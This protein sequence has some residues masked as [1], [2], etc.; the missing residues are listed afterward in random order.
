V[1]A[2]GDVITYTFDVTNTGN[3]TIN[4]ITIHDTQ[5]PPATQANLTGLSCPQSTLAPGATENCTATYTVTK[6][7]LLN[8]SITDTATATGTTDTGTPVTSNPSQATVLATEIVMSGRAYALGMSASL[9]S[10]VAIVGP[11]SVQ[12]TGATDTALSSTTPNPCAADLNVLDVALTGDV[13][14][15]VTTSAVTETSTANSSV[16][17]AVITLGH[18]I[19]VIALQA[20]SS[21]STTSCA[22]S[23]GST[24]IVALSIG[25][26]AV[27][28]PN[29]LPPNFGINL[30]IVTLV[31]NQQIP[32]NFGGDKG[33]TVYAI[34][35]A[36]N[37]PLVARANVVVAA[38]T[39]DIACAA[40]FKSPLFT[41]EANVANLTASA[42]G[43]SVL[44][45]ITVNDSGPVL[46]QTPT[47]STAPC[48]ASL[49]IPDITFTGEA[50]AGV[51]TTSTTST[52]SAS[53]ANA[54]IAVPN[55]VPTIVVQALQ[56]QSSTTCSGSSGS[57][58]IAYLQIGSTVL[59]KKPTT[60]QPNTVFVVGPVTL[61]LNKQTP[62]N[63]GGD[64]G[65][66]VTGLAVNVNL[67]ATAQANLTIANSISDIIGCP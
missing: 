50:C 28:I 65:L 36:V 60:V 39:S 27:T 22:G 16:A 35:V 37:V 63:I 56:S 61:T 44:G 21:T 25:G 2:P 19:P 52:A 15:R 45:D 20:V 64:S 29:P 31:L 42:L 57:V 58:T 23:S 48:V 33:L 55:I 13:C 12:D 49:L 24:T 38:S 43:T 41:G 53:V 59:I 32:F 9:L 54:A 40:P 1:H 8:G 6:A 62:F 46:T 10:G 3:V 5:L 67:G 4:G 11:D 17:N 34:H 14:S 18:G 26:V 66:K 30:G 7:D 51:T 47:T